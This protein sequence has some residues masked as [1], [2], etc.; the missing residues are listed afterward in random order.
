MIYLYLASLLTNQKSIHEEIRS[1]LKTE[2]SY[3]YLHSQLLF[4]NFNIKI[5]ETTILPILL[6]GCEIWSYNKGGMHA[7]D[8]WEKNSEVNIWTQKENEN[9][10][11][12]FHIGTS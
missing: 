3:Y 4:K 6:H 1:W 11:W 12:K 7:K 8:V 9:G 2:N 5:C 10:E